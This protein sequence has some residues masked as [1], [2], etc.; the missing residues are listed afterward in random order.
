M[1]LDKDDLNFALSPDK[2]YISALIQRKKETPGK[3]C[4]DFEKNQKGDQLMK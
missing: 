4:N 3:D 1:N 2:M